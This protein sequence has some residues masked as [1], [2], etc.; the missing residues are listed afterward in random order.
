[1]LSFHSKI[2]LIYSALFLVDYEE[3]KGRCAKGLTEDQCRSVA[4]RRGLAFKK[5]TEGNWPPKCYQ[6]KTT[7]VFFNKHQNN[8]QCNKQN[9]EACFCSN[10]GE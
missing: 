8:V 1:M 9:V 10:Q 4:E 2:I 5:E 6:Y 3:R 7:T